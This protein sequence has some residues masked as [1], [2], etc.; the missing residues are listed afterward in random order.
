MKRSR[1]TRRFYLISAIVSAA[2][3]AVG[4]FTPLATTQAQGSQPIS[5]SNADKVD[6]IAKLEGHKSAVFGLAF[7]PD[8]Q[9]LA[10]AGVDMTVRLWAVQTAKQTVQFDGHTKPA[11]LIGFSAD[12]TT[13][14]TMGYEPALRIWDVK[15]GKQ[16][17]VQQPD[18]NATDITAVEPRLDG[19][20]G[21]I[22]PDAT[23]LAHADGEEVILWSIKDK[24][25]Y[26]LS[27]NDSQGTAEYGP[28]AFSRDGKFIAAAYA[29]S[30]DSEGNFVHIW[31]VDDVLKQTSLADAGGLVQNG[32]PPTSIATGAPESYY[33][34]A[35]AL[36]PDGTQIAVEDIANSS[37]RILDVKTGKE[38]VV[39]AP[40]FPKD[41]SGMM[42]NYIH[43]L[44]FSPDG[45]LLA[46][47]SYD[48]TVRLWDVKAGKE[49]KVLTASGQAA[50]VTFSADG[51]LLASSTT[52]GPI[53]IWGVK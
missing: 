21:A 53:D 23:L 24:K 32:I 49:L 36:S 27:S 18:P 38:I 52:D 20:Y 19:L 1:E 48:K 30:Q 29:K 13:V 43:G 44:T 40:P 10:S 12:G 28:L 31:N 33:G 37:I 25:A 3:I 11:I 2:I 16:S 34:N 9:L 14:V 26:K 46:V 50:T 17:A 47:G 22:S 8:G 45:S 41:D 51:L 39:L 35:L 15:S 42:D 7:S 6:R 5:I 4:F